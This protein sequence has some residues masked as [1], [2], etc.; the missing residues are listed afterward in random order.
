MYR[1]NV[2]VVIM[3]E[4]V[5]TNVRFGTETKSVGKYC[6]QSVI[7]EWRRTGDGRWGE[8]LHRRWALMIHCKTKRKSRC[9]FNNWLILQHY[10]DYYDCVPS[11]ILSIGLRVVILAVYLFSFLVFTFKKCFLLH[12]NFC[13]IKISKIYFVIQIHLM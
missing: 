2:C 1:V 12:F 11:W 13:H 7:R 5:W 10:R 6:D 3:F 4:E 8:P 9:F